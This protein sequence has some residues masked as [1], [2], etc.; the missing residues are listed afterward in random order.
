MA[1]TRFRKYAWVGN[2]IAEEDMA[3]LYAIKSEK[4]IP[5]T[6]QVSD[7]VRKY[8]ANRHD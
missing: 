3:K 7:A 5:I 1:K 2:K 8:L 6:K 4:K